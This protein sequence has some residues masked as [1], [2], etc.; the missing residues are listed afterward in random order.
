M[1][2]PSERAIAELEDVAYRRAY[3]ADHIRETVALQ[4]R[5]LRVR[6]NWTQ[7]QLGC[8]ADMAQERIS[9]LEDPDGRLPSLTTLLRIGNAFDCALIVRYVSFSN[10]LGSHIGLADSQLAPPSFPEDILLLDLAEEAPA[11]TLSQMP[12]TDV[13]DAPSNVTNIEA[14]LGRRPTSP[15]NQAICPQYEAT[16]L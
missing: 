4:I 14:F 1:F 6:N 9:H 15:A 10:L 5:K 2:T 12:Y 13:G 3:V 7:E 11:S 16:S 8:A